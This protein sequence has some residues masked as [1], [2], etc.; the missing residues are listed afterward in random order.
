MLLKQSKLRDKATQV[1]DF[2]LERKIFRCQGIEFQIYPD[3]KNPR[4]P[5]LAIKR[6]D[7]TPPKRI[8]GL[9]S[10]GNV[11]SGDSRRG[12]ARKD[13]LLEIIPENKTIKLYGF[14][15][16]LELIGIRAPIQQNTLFT[17]HQG[18]LERGLYIIGAT[19]NNNSL[20][21]ANESTN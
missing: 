12:D 3:T 15:E 4:T 7:T 21:I 6:N 1:V 2:D 20:N 18:A 5:D 11:L 8:S 19:G 14:R 9:W 17:R 16:A 13:F 10:R